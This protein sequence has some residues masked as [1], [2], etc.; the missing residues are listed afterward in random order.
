MRYSTE[1]AIKGRAGAAN[2]PSR[3]LAQHAEMYGELISAKPRTRALAENAKR[4]IASNQPPNKPFEPSINPYRG[5]EHDCVYCNARSSH[6][7][8]GM[9]PDLDLETRLHYKP[10]TAQLLE[11]AITHKNYLCQAIT[12]GANADPYQPIEKNY[13]LTR[14]SLEVLAR[15]KHPVTIITKGTLIER[16]I[17]LLAEM[18][19]ENL[20]SVMVSVTTLDDDLRRFMEPRAASPKARLSIISELAAHNIPVGALV[21]PIIPRINDQEMESILE[22]V[23]VAGASSACYRFIRLPIDLEEQFESWLQ[24]H[25]PE[26]AEQVMSQ[27]RQGR[28]GKASAS[29]VDNHIS[30]EG[31][32]AQLLAQRFEFAIRKLGLNKRAHSLDTSRF[33]L[34]DHGQI[35]LFG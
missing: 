30:G 3:F 35:N 15:Y 19:S 17:P 10:N 2:P 26:R 6:T 7:N 21:S 29:S 28:S 34:A 23:K 8:Q 27:V 20:V 16:D 33:T 9:L 14:Q 4:I 22:A 31:V 18:A 12:L 5:C 32:F 1:R 11:Q 24:A 25:Y 13:G